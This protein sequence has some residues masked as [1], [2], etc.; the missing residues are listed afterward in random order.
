LTERCKENA[1][2]NASSSWLQGKRAAMSIGVDVDAELPILAEGVGYADHAMTM[3]HERF[4]PLVGVPRILDFL[5]D[6]D[7]KAT[8][9]IPGLA[10]ER[11]PAMVEAVLSAGHEVGHHS[12]SHRTSVSMTADEER[13][14]LERGLE[15]LEQFGVK[16]RGYRS[17]MW[18]AAW[19]TFDL[20]AEYGFEYDSTLMD[21]DRPYMLETA[22][23][24]L[25]E[26]PPHWML[27]DWEQYAF[28][29]QP[30]VGQVIEAP[31]KVLDLWISE[32]DALRRYDGLF[33][34]TLHPSLSGRASRVEVLRKLVAQAVDWG[35]VDILS[36]GEIAERVRG[37]RSL[38]T[39]TLEPVEI[40]PGLYPEGKGIYS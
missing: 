39:R 10:A 8:F 27:D 31:T 25:V 19:R 15:A 24:P 28:L 26:L 2:S 11:Y 38:P 5:Q 16:P 40:E 13:R 21:D 35:D 23:G 7:L 18:E 33:M 4:G 3:S 22:H 30:K 14:D 20:I 37:D 32:L 6:F 29:P 1:V 9:F 17:P 12:Y 36:A 34:L